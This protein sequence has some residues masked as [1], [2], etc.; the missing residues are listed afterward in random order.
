MTLLR[1]WGLLLGLLLPLIVL[2]HFKKKQVV[3][4]HVSSIRLWDEVI[5]EIEGIKRKRF[6]PILLLFIQIIIGLCILLAL[7]QPIWTKGIKGDRI[8][9]ALDVSI[10]MNMEESG[11]SRL[12]NGKEKL[13]EYIA[14]L[15]DNIRINLLLLKRNNEVYLEEADKKTILSELNKIGCS[16][17]SLDLERASRLLEGYAEEKVIV[18][19]KEIFLEF[20]RIK[21]NGQAENLGIINCQYDPY[22]KAALCT[23]KNY[24]G[25]DRQGRIRIS[26]SGGRENLYEFSIAP[27]EEK[28]LQFSVNEKDA[29]VQFLLDQN[30][31]LYVDNQFILPIGKDYQ[32]KV[33]Y[34][35]DN[36]Y[37]LKA[38]ETIPYILVEQ[39]SRFEKEAN[40]YDAYIIE[41]EEGLENI[42]HNM[43]LWSL[44]PPQT[45]LIEKSS[46]PLHIEAMDNRFT[47][48]LLPQG[49]QSEVFAFLKEDETYE[50]I[51]EAEGKTVMACRQKNGIRHLYSTIDL[52][53][54]N[55]IMLTDF[56]IL[57]YRLT[58]WLIDGYDQNNYPGDL[59]YPISDKK[60]ELW[61][62]K[63]KIGEL[64]SIPLLLQDIGI[65]TLMVEDNK[66]KSLVVNPP[67][68]FVLGEEQQHEEMQSYGRKPILYLN[69]MWNV[70]ALIFLVVEWEVYRRGY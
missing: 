34:I 5:Q 11:K 54:S 62:E 56:P 36:P 41:K 53:Q 13:G 15:P 61:L 38:L 3:E 52:E 8:T 50:R 22:K 17:E 58:E 20:P 59:I 60:A 37:L 32:K 69:D 18:T 70:L 47:R 1:P 57:V 10:S 28:T 31:S 19:D 14:S 46:R 64:D 45:L 65:Y 7:C 42:P 24:G 49:I 23:I 55:L 6:S 12:D 26:T 30:D 29:Y 63:R 2:L 16:K 4:Q 40:F 25:K 67:K 48:N 35:G 43:P 27:M 51:L 33:L 9:I 68:D 44:K 39:K 21:I 66:I